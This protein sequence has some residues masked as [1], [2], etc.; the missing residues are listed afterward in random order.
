MYFYFLFFD[1]VFCSYHAYFDVVF[2]SFY[3]YRNVFPFRFSSFASSVTST[4]ILS[5]IRLV[6]Y[7]L[8]LLCPIVTICDR[9]CYSSSYFSQIFPRR[10]LYGCRNSF[11]PLSQGGSCFPSIFFI[12]VSGA[13]FPF[14]VIFCLQYC[15]LSFPWLCCL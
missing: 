8:Y 7:E 13:G 14:L 6:W 3:C 10:C 11:S 1:V 2:F 9:F 4:Y 5:Y 12:I 15:C